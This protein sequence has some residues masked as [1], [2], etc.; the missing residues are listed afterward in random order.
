MRKHWHKGIEV[1]QNK[2]FDKYICEKN[3]GFINNLVIDTY[4]VIFDKIKIH[5]ET[6]TVF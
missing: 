2:I 3:K 5:V 4:M 6:V 1:Y